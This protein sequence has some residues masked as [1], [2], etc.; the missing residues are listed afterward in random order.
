MATEHKDLGAP[1]IFSK[2]LDRLSVTSFLNTTLLVPGRL[3][4]QMDSASTV[5]LGND[6]VL[7]VRQPRAQHM[8]TLPIVYRKKE[9]SLI[10]AEDELERRL[11]DS[12]CS[13]QHL[14]YAIVSHFVSSRSKAYDSQC[15]MQKA[16]TKRDEDSACE[17]EESTD[18]EELVLS[19][20]VALVIMDTLPRK[21]RE[22]IGNVLRNNLE[23]TEEE[24][25]TDAKEAGLGGITLKSLKTLRRHIRDL[26]EEEMN[27]L[28]DVT[29]SR[30]T[31]QLTR[32]LELKK[33]T[34][35]A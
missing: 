34:Q 31:P 30:S 24:N 33:N 35:E 10:K 1:P 19:F 32:G 6:R 14:N 27:L 20:S 5:R 4:T 15:E 25:L 7:Y 29:W 11:G 22:M 3:L 9:I 13:H 23:G 28:M 26:D 17:F 21:E 12:K 16:I 2:L 8:R 18:F